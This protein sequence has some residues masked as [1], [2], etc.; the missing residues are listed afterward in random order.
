MTPRSVYHNNNGDDE[1]DRYIVKFNR[2]GND[3]KKR[4]TGKG[5]NKGKILIGDHVD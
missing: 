5:R 2:F 3:R 1:K 4:Q